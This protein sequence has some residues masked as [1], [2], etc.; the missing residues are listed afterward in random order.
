MGNRARGEKEQ[1]S[2]SRRTQERFHEERHSHHVQ[3]KV[4][5][6]V[7]YMEEII[8]SY[9]IRYEAVSINVCYT[10]IHRI[11]NS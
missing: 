4:Q 3:R 1:K 2:M 6:F 7:D 5:N 10:M 9:S 8:K 11:T